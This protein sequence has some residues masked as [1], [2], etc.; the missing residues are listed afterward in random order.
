METESEF[1]KLKCLRFN[2]P[3]AD[4]HSIPS[5]FILASIILKNKYSNKMQRS[6]R[7]ATDPLATGIQW[8]VLIYRHEPQLANVQFMNSTRLWALET[9]L[10]W[11]SCVTKM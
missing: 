10:F 6:V 8:L 1:A 11:L 2:S 5:M 9:A 3:L 7:Q 4:L